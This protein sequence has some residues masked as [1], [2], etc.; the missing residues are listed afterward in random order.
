MKKILLSTICYSLPFVIWGI[1]ALIVGIHVKDS[2]WVMSMIGLSSLFITYRWIKYLLKIQY[3]DSLV[4]FLRKDH[5]GIYKTSLF[6]PAMLSM[7]LSVFVL[8]AENNVMI[9]I[10]FILL[11]L[12]TS[13]LLLNIWFLVFGVLERF[14]HYYEKGA[15]ELQDGISTQLAKESSRE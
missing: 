4:S 8:P 7:L 13:I 11:L 12:F 14:A 1:P 2:R 3:V 9:F 15:G 5:F 6:F 10:D